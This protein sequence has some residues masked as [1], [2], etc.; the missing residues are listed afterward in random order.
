MKSTTENLSAGIYND[1]SANPQNFVSEPIKSALP[2]SLVGPQKFAVI[3]AR[4]SDV[5]VTRWNIGE[6][7]DIMETLN[8]FWYNASYHTVT[9]SYQVE[10]WYDLPNTK[11]GYSPLYDG[12]PNTADGW[13]DVIDDAIALAD[14]DIN[15]ANFDYILVWINEWWRGISTVGDGYQIVT[16]D[17]TFNVAVSLVG[18][19]SP[20]PESAVWGRVAHE[21]GHSFGLGHTHQDY[22]SYYA[23][24]AR[25]YPS[26]LNVYSQMQ[27]EIG[28]FDTSTN[29]ETFYPGDA[30]NTFVVRP[31]SLDISGDLQSL[32]VVVTYFSWG[33][34][35][36]PFTYYL[37]EVVNQTSEDGWVSD[38]GVLIYF[39]DPFSGVEPCTDMDAKSG[40][41]T[42]VDCLYDVGETFADSANSIT[43]EVVSKAGY[44]GYLIRV[45]N[46]AGPT[47][48]MIRPWGSEGSISNWESPDIWVD[49]PINGW[50]FYR[51][52]DNLGN[53]IGVGDDPW[54][55][56]RNKLW[57]TIHNIGGTTV[58]DAK[59]KFYERVPI[60][61]GGPWNLIDETTVTISPLTSKDVYVNWT[62]ELSECT[63]ATGIVRLHGCVK[64]VIE[65]VTGEINTGNNEAQEN[66][67]YYE[68]TP[69]TPGLGTQWGPLC[70]CILIINPLPYPISAYF[71]FMR[72]PSQWQWR[73]Q[74]ET[75]FGRF[76]DL[77]VEESKAFTLELNIAEDIPFETL[78]EAGVV[79]RT[80]F[81]E[82]TG[83][84]EFTGDIHLEAIGGV[85]IMAQTL[86][87]S[88]MNLTARPDG[89]TTIEVTGTL[90][91]LD[92][93]PPTV[94][95]DG[96]PGEDRY[97]Y[98]ELTKGATTYG[99]KVVEIEV[100]GV[101]SHSFTD[102]TARGEY[103]ITAYYGGSNALASSSASTT[104]QLM[105]VPTPGFLWETVI[106]AFV[107][108]LIVTVFVRRRCRTKSKSIGYI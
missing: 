29:Q 6:I 34:I 4:Y 18:E 49:S 99:T 73:N 88:S 23:L 37:V 86:Y 98:L 22:N 61:I 28:W 70:L 30:E 84:Q 44:D 7:E 107:M 103:T 33:V 25:A 46:D 15:F 41:A 32:Q 12:D 42:L 40:T 59:V 108:T 69:G 16:N 19:N 81:E 13:D 68:I 87:R 102:I 54:I 50:N 65:P 95:G 3:C 11:N 64:V 62:P 66:I 97:I 78:I 80:V 93:A 51:Y 10:G 105:G 57:A 24:M 94:V 36:Y 56:H 85:S 71:N 17:G 5:A 27:P 53:P 58:T 14:G 106:L 43:I 79:M 20:D 100:G 1:E 89:N 35:K 76:Y 39:V 67:D 104:A 48:L 2:T 91:A 52:R 75:P 63:C 26:D 55:E 90:F 38:E 74:S 9:I 31:R 45:N 60:G 72:D 47:D 77:D 92:N 8:D 96:I 83:E 21:M 82:E 101:F